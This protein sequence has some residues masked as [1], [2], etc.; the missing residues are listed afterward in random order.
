MYRG[1][2][3]IGWLAHSRAA[4]TVG[5]HPSDPDT[6]VLA[7]NKVNLGKK[8]RAIG[9]TVEEVE[10]DIIRV[11]WGEELELTPDDLLGAPVFA[12]P[13]KVEEC[14]QVIRDLLAGGERPSA[15][16]TELL[17]DMGFSRSTQERARSR[18]KV[19]TR[20]E[21]FGADGRHFMRLPGAATDQD[22]EAQP[23][24]QAA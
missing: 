8:P 16:V 14:E 2:S 6:R 20:C 9:Y 10:K 4:L 11:V 13:T 19:R 17:D 12:K 5:Q 7:V 3:S 24:G 23:E 15:E 21:G 22:T 18:L 1:L